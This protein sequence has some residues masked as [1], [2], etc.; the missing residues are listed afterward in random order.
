MVFTG[1]LIGVI[2][3]TS[4]VEQKFVLPITDKGFR[5]FHLGGWGS[6]PDPLYPF[7]TWKHNSAPFSSYWN[8][9]Q[10]KFVLIWNEIGSLTIKHGCHKLNVESWGMPYILNSEG[11]VDYGSIRIGGDYRSGQDELGS[12]PRS[13][14]GNQ[15]LL[16][17]SGSFFGGLRRDLS[18]I[19]GLF[20]RRPHFDSE[21]RIDDQHNQSTNGHNYAY[22]V[23]KLGS[24]PPLLN[25]MLPQPSESSPDSHH[26]I[27]EFIVGVFFCWLGLALLMVMLLYD[28]LKWRRFIA[29]GFMASIGIFVIVHSGFV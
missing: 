16:R 12:K 20:V 15:L 17:D 3:A 11:V 8:P 10:T 9:T 25:V 27:L 18:S 6:Y 22:A 24:L 28:C 7:R 5:P 2:N 19:G 26:S 29:C 13:L 1:E 4:G 23:V 21:D 14:I